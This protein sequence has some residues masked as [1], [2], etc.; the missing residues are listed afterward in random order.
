MSIYVGNLP[1][2][3]TEDELTS[4]FLVY[5][6][7]RQVRLPINHKKNALCGF[8][9]IEMGTDSEESAAIAALNHVVYMGRNLRV[10]KM[11]P[12][13]DCDTESDWFPL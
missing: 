4:V 6:V 1:S 9:L 5:G 10:I 12:N 7:V 13:V 11:M 2:S 3:I 8:G